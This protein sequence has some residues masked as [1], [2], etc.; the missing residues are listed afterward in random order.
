MS[1]KFEGRFQQI[2]GLVE[3]LKL[4]VRQLENMMVRNRRN[5]PNCGDTANERKLVSHSHEDK[6]EKSEGRSDFHVDV[7]AE[8]P[9]RLANGEQRNL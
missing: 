9:H 6:M 5:A 4:I 2:F 1:E 3:Q 7:F 8:N